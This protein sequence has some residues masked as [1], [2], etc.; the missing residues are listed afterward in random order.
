MRILKIVA[1]CAAL[2]GCGF[3]RQEMASTSPL[4]DQS[5]GQNFVGQN[6]TSLVNQF[7]KPVSRKKTDTGQTSYVW[8][9]D[10]ATESADDRRFDS[11]DG[12]LYGDGHTP[13]YMTDDQR[14]CKMTVAVSPE[15][16]VT[17]VTTEDQNGTGAPSMTIGLS[18]GIC[19]Q[20]LRTKPRT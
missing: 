15:G 19:A 12:G 4:G 16:I 3:P 17:Q 6:V 8:E 7:G 14:L 5:V 2:G 18:R 13:G 10:A 1:L 20:R 9:L 11:G